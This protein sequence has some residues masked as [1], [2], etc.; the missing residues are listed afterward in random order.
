MK[1][2]TFYAVEDEMGIVSVRNARFITQK[3]VFSCRADAE[4]FARAS[5]VS[6]LKVVP[7]Y[8]A[9]DKK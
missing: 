1:N 6:G 4:D 5:T 3:A 2:Y 8:I 7:V 9:M